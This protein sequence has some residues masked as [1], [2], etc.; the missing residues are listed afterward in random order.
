M[1]LILLNDVPT[2]FF[3]NFRKLSFPTSVLVTSL[4]KK[5]KCIC[6]DP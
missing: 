1:L 3:V 6:L 5:N 2:Y 4:I